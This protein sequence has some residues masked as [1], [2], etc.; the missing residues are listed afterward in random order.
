[1]AIGTIFWML[2]LLWLVFGIFGAWQPESGNRYWF[3]HGLF[4]FILFFLLGWA[5]FGFIIQGK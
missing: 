3:G 5:Q 2:M 1:M 4:A